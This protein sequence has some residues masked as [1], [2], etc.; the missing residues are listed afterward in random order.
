MPTT[1][2]EY[3]NGFGKGH[4]PEL[5]GVE[6]LTVSPEAVESRLPIRREMRAFA[7]SHRPMIESPSMQRW[8]FGFFFY[9]PCLLADR[10]G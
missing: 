9:F 4:L 10:T 8:F 7:K 2:R 5:V 3:F 6:I 1:T